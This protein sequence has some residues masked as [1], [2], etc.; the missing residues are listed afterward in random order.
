MV[1]TCLFLSML[2]GMLTAY[3]SSFHL[4]VSRLRLRKPSCGCGTIHLIKGPVLKTCQLSTGLVGSSL[5]RLFPA[6]KNR[7]CTGAKKIIR[8]HILMI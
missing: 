2:T 6:N 1:L 4:W 7:R 5:V 3:R 8:R